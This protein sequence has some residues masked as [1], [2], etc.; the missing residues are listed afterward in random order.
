MKKKGSRIQVEADNI[1]KAS[2][3][4]EEMIKVL[5]EIPAHGQPI[6]MWETTSDSDVW[7]YEDGFTKE[8]KKR[9]M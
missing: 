6:K 7:M 5:T 4:P 3:R 1:V 8:V 2:R 9:A